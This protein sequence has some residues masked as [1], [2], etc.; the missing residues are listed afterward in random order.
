M[1]K[2]CVSI[3]TFLQTL[4]KNNVR[5]GGFSVLYMFFAAGVAVF[6]IL[7]FILVGQLG[8]TANS[9]FVAGTANLDVLL[10]LLG[11]LAAVTVGEALFSSLSAL[12]LGRKSGYI[13]HKF[14][15]NFAK[16]FLYTPFSKFSQANSGQSLSVFSNDVPSAATFIT[17]G[18]LQT[19]GSILTLV[20]AFIFMFTINVTFTLIFLVMFPVL[21]VM[22]ILLSAPIQKWQKKTS[23]RTAEFNAVVNDSLQ[24]ISTITAYGLEGELEKRYLSKYD[25]FIEATR[26]RIGSFLP[27]VMFGVLASSAPLLV[28]VIG[29][30]IAT[31]EG[32]MYLGE[33]IALIAIAGIAGE[34]LNMLAQ[35]LNM[36][37]TWR[38]G[39][40]RFNEQTAHMLEDLQKGDGL[41][42]STGADIIF[43]DVSFAYGEGDEAFQALTDVSFHIKPG[44]RVAFVGG[45]GSGK[46]TVL[47]M[48][49]GLYE[50]ASGKISIGGKDVTGVS[51]FSQ[52]EYF[53]YV[54]QDSFLFP[55]TIGQNIACSDKPDM[56]RLRSVCRDAGILE[57]IESLPEKFDTVLVESAENVSGGQR[58]RI[59]LARAFYK[60][61]PVVL[62]D[63]ATS[64]LD[65]ITEAQVLEAFDELA[66][67]K[68][69]VMVAHR[70][71]A[72]AA[73][74]TIVVMDGG[75][76]A[77]IGSHEELIANNDAYKNLYQS[78]T[79]T[80]T[81]VA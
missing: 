26:K 42:V 48:L 45:S 39:A 66:K 18:M 17:N 73:C 77:G 3:K 59:A 25:L 44:S 64:A 72:I 57:F 19:F 33:Y 75:K 50:P 6:S 10:R 23:E 54:P 13:G 27:L 67:G 5:I 37:Q 22:Q 74:D 16:Y 68:T 36:I 52:R 70:A 58:Q 55:E 47:K 56:E 78:R 61:A 4:R 8:Q 2:G 81:E 76:I 46:S 14:R 40:N 51:K 65:P 20:A 29:S 32:N 41:K 7:S 15:Q 71:R 30:T 38:A 34:W 1:R 43:R 35:N 31:I 9:E 53:T 69:V 79:V 49:L 62:F 60:D 80:E 21:M 12:A 63:E 28:L 24:N 11:L